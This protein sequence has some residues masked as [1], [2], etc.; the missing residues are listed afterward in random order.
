MERSTEE[1]IGL[2]DTFI[3]FSIFVIVA[4]ATVGLFSLLL[5]GRLIGFL[6][7]LLLEDSLG[8]FVSHLKDLLLAASN[9][10]HRGHSCLAGARSQGTAKSL[11]FYGLAGDEGSYRPLR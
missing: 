9:S 11:R 6:Q 5:G 4:A 2:A 3:V 10:K 8:L 7:L 1:P